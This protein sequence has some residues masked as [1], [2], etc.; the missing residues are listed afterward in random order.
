MERGR[1]MHVCL[2]KCVSGTRFDLGGHRPV[3]DQERSSEERLVANCNHIA[4][5]QGPSNRR[6]SSILDRARL[7]RI[8]QSPIFS[9]SLYLLA[10]KYAQSNTISRYYSFFYYH[11]TDSCDKLVLF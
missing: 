6:D 10:V 2:H 3:F 5:W 7:A 11:T 1:V 8:M 9:S 4:F